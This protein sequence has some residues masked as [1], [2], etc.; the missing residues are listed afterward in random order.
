MPLESNDRRE[1]RVAKLEA[2]RA[3]GIEPF[4]ARVSATHTAAQALAAFEP[5]A[6]PSAAE[7][8]AVVVAVPG[9]VM[10]VRVMGKSLFAHIA[11]GT[12]RIQV[13]LR[14]DVVGAEAYD[15]FR[16]LVD[17]GDF[18]LVHGRL[19]R[20]RTGEITIEASA[21]EFLSKAL[22][23]L[24]EKWHGLRDV[25]LRYR[26]RYLDLLTNDEARRIFVL[27]TRAVSAVRRFLD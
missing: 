18:C 10:A 12:G 14:Q 21:W 1:Q 15:A 9:R 11:D 2:L 7:G 4:P 5:A 23:P 27:R 13:Y 8:E 20:T 19:F 6:G 17:L 16:K 3:Q 25:E 24:P 26:Q 22:R